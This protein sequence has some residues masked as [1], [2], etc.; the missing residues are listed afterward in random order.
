MVPKAAGKRDFCAKFCKKRFEAFGI[1]DARHR[2]YPPAFQPDALKFLIS[3]AITKPDGLFDSPEYL[4]FRRELLESGLSVLAVVAHDNDRSG[5]L[6]SSCRFPQVT[7]RHNTPAAEWPSTG[8]HYNI[9]VAMKLP[10]LQSVVKNEQVRLPVFEQS[11]CRALAPFAYAHRHIWQH[12]PQHCGFIAYLR[13][14]R[15][16]RQ[17]WSAW[18][19]GGK[20]LSIDWH[21]EPPGRLVRAAW[22]RRKDNRRPTHSASIAPREYGG[23]DAR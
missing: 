20:I 7:R 13:R 4:G 9:Q 5:S 12:L 10:V 16:A 8:Y 19:A 14:I 15:H 18:R 6:D 11:L 2:A 3:S 1:P 23:S 17:Q 21:G 22:L